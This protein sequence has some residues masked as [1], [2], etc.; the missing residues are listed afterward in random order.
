MQIVVT[1]EQVNALGVIP[2]KS[3]SLHKTHF[4]NVFVWESDHSIVDVDI[5]PQ[6]VSERLVSVI[7]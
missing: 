1:M 4:L 2:W 7:Y 3:L 5:L 6:L